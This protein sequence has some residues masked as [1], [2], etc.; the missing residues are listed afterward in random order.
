VR[1]AKFAEA[2]T[3]DSGGSQPRSSLGGQPQN[4]QKPGKSGA[5]KQGPSKQQR[6]AGSTPEDWQAKRTRQ[7]GKHSYAGSAREVFRVAVVNYDYPRRQISRE[8]FA[9][10]QREIGRLVDEIPEEV[11]I[12]RLVVS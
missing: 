7:S 11:F 3:K 6:S 1:K 4:L 8:N 2:P 12:P 5:H 10:I 9:D